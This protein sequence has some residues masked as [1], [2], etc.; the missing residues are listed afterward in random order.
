MNI[1]SFFEKSFEQYPQNNALFVK[2]RHY[3][4]QELQ[5]LSSHISGKLTCGTPGFTGLLA[6]RSIWAFAGVLGILRTGCAYVPLNPKLPAKRLAAIINKSNMD[7]LIVEA[8]YL[9]VFHETD[10][11]LDKAINIFIPDEPDKSYIINKRH[12][13]IAHRSIMNP[14]GQLKRKCKYA[15]ML[16]TSGSTGMPKGVPISHENVG[17][18]INNINKMN[19]FL[20][21]DRFSNTF[22]LTFDLSVHDMFICWSNGAEL[23]CIPENALMAPAKYMKKHQLTCWFSVPTLANTMD[24][25]RMLKPNSFSHLRYSFFCGEP[26]PELLAENWQKAA[27]ESVIKNIYGPTEATIGIT[28]Y[29]YNSEKCKSLN[30]ILSIGKVFPGNEMKLSDKNEDG[31]EELMLSGCQ[32][33]TQY[34]KEPEKTA[35]AF[36]QYEGKIWYK[37]GDRIKADQE[38]Y[39]YFLGRTDYQIKVQGYRVE[40]GE[41]DF[42]ISSFRKNINV[43]TFARQ[44]NNTITLIS[45]I[46]DQPDN[47][48]VEMREIIYHCKKL[49]PTYMIPSK[50]LFFPNFPMNT[51][52]KINYS[53]LIDMAL[54]KIEQ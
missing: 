51:N 21:T 45:C 33:T 24:R 2:D 36:V 50:I 54:K 46:N 42:V 15:Y 43:F 34:W 16:F 20:P 10:K 28:S 19:N 25:F 49:L 9:P 3:T 41:I 48:E 5:V 14:E 53:Q 22:D 27:P 7:T 29:T 38:G 47:K 37:T 35:Q 17:C 31:Q 40:P 39:L 30:G 26:M 23:F 11:F 6:H 32:V 4:Y 44:K 52:G 1:Y 8:E 18:Y 12:N 13:I